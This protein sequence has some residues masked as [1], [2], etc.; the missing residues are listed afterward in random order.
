MAI[1]DESIESFIEQYSYV[2]GEGVPCSVAE[3]R[4]WYRDALKIM[5][6]NIKILCRELSA[7]TSQEINY[8]LLKKEERD[9][10]MNDCD[11]VKRCI[12]EYQE[13]LE[14]LGDLYE[15]KKDY[16]AWKKESELD[17]SELLGINSE[18]CKEPF[19]LK[20]SVAYYVEKKIKS[21]KGMEEL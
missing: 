4:T 13:V 18:K 19:S 12:E 3:A 1:N 21:S 15:N 17:I 6:E 14:L 9:M 8:Y 5:Q 11:C 16:F 7:N 20:K 10:I 2:K